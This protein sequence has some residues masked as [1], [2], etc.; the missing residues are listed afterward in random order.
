MRLVLERVLI[1]I[2]TESDISKVK[3]ND[4]NE[5]PSGRQSI[6]RRDIVASIDIVARKSIDTVARKSI[7]TIANKSFDTVAAVKGKDLRKTSLYEDRRW[8]CFS[9][10]FAI[11]RALLI[12][13][14]IDKGEES[15]DEAFTQE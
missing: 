4:Y 7:D 14:M 8:L 6:V 13:E 15:M 3:L 12:A 1:L 2:R 9:Q 5:A 10:P 11:L